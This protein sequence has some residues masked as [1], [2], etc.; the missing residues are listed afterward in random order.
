MNRQ[1]C[2]RLVAVPLCCLLLCV[3][4]GCGNSKMGKVNGVVTMDGQPVADAFIKFI[5]KGDQGTSS[6][7]K[8]ESDGSYQMRFSDSEYGALIGT[9][10]VTI[11]TGDVKAD[12][13]GSVPETVPD[14]YNTKTTL[15]AEVKSGKNVLDFDLKSE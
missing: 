8:T 14:I 10:H 9:Y 1:N 7:G 2:F 11:S 3:F 13:S 12:N 6:F 5:P 4:A 15:S